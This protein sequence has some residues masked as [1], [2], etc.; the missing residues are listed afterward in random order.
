[1]I[2]DDAFDVAAPLDRVWPVLKDIPKVAGCIPRAEIT[3]V[4]DERTYR[5]KVGVKVGPVEVG[6]RAT[7]EVLAMDDATHTA[8]FK[9][10]GDEL[11]G[12]G[13]TNAT[14]VTTAS[15]RDGTTHVTL[16][17]DAQISG[18]VATVGGRLIEGVAQ[19]TV[20]TFAANLSKLV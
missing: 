9:V 12:R 1:M 14:V 20:A 13:G 17:T 6:Y 5:A 10:R 8:S 7:I 15:E 18:I 11:R 16:H 3:E 4:V 2:I 19:K